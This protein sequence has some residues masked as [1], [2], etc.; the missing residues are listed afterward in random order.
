MDSSVLLAI[1]GGAVA[2]VFAG[3]LTA[4]V[5]RKPPGNARMIEIAGA[6]QEGAH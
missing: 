6:I 1:L 3:V 5:L 4:I 2:V